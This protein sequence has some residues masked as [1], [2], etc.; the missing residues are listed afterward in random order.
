MATVL[1]TGAASGLGWA[2]AR[3]FYQRGEHLLLI[4]IQQELL[5]QRLQE[6]EALSG[7]NKVMSYTADLS[8]SAEIQ[9]LI[10]QI[11][12]TQDGLDILINNAGIT[13]R[14]LAEET[15]PSVFRKVMDIDYRGPVELTLGLLPLLKN[16]KGT[17]INI[18]SMASWMPVLGRAGYCAAKSAMN[19]FFETLRCEVR[20]YGVRILMVYPS[21]VDTPIEHNALGFDGKPAK[22]RRSMIGKMESAE[23][24]TEQIIIALEKG[25]ERLFPDRYTWAA[26][27]LYKV[28]PRVYQKQMTQRFASELEV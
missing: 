13:H 20:Q 15:C 24:I 1:I 16:K 4:D 25:R 2:M 7:S 19:Q 17:I 6:L 12:D 3:A 18:S 22:H 10:C 26:S 28:L 21:F 8:D 23:S 11:N 14:S 5:N 27:L 9:R